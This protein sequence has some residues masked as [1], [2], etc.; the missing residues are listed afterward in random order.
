MDFNRT[1]SE[2]DAWL[3]PFRFQID[4]LGAAA[5]VEVMASG[6]MRGADLIEALEACARA[7]G[8]ASSQL[9][10][11][12]ATVPAWVDFA[13]MES[14]ARLGL[15]TPVQSGLTLVLGS[16]I[17]SYAAARGAKVLI[18]GGRL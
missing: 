12:A 9:L 11:E 13:Q 15:R 8:K 4:E 14:G 5:A 16:L 18:R 2:V 3:E 7:G 6:K 1:D 17:E 10:D